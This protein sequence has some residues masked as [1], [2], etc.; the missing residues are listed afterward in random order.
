MGTGASALSTNTFT[1]GLRTFLTPRGRL[2]SLFS[3]GFQ[4]DNIVSRGSGSLSGVL[5]T[6]MTKK[7]VRHCTL[8]NQGEREGWTAL[9]G[10]LVI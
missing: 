6:G 2:G 8:D 10:C 5:S 3:G 4:D 7:M 9:T 1:G